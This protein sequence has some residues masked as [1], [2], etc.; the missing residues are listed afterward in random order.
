[1]WLAGHILQAK[2]VR[3]Y[4]EPA[5]PPCLPVY[6]GP[7]ENCVCRAS[8]ME[9]Y[10]EGKT[11]PTIPYSMRG[12]LKAQFPF[13]KADGSNDRE[14]G[15]RLYELNHWMMLYG[16][17]MKRDNTAA[18]G[19]AARVARRSE[20]VR[21]AWETRRKRAARAHEYGLQY[22]NRQRG[23]NSAAVSA[24]A[25]AEMEASA[26]VAAE[27]DSEDPAPGL[28]TVPG[29]AMK[30][31]NRGGRPKG[32]PAAARQRRVGAAA[33]R[34]PG[35]RRHGNI[36]SDSDAGYGSYSYSESDSENACAASDSE[37]DSDVP[38]EVIDALSGPDSARESEGER[39]ALASA[40]ESD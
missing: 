5:D 24:D 36:D 6:V 35:R 15:S 38:S 22:G 4:Y 14:N 7:A 11:R 13:G 16:R 8:L 9:C 37:P 34:G 17:G 18:E 27:M 12:Q 1:M 29:R 19:E 30:R 26:E 40:S 25:A 28:S 21:R 2:G 39:D 10:M 23:H 31:R 32:R 20:A 33:A 3:Q